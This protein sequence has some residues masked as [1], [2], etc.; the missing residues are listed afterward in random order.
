MSLTLK[1][2]I[3]V[4]GKQELSQLGL[5][6]SYESSDSSSKA[7][8]SSLVHT[9][10]PSS[11]THGLVCPEAAC[12]GVCLGKSSVRERLSSDMIQGF[13]FLPLSFVDTRDKPAPSQP[14]P[15]ALDPTPNHPTPPRL[16]LL[17]PCRISVIWF[18]SLCQCLVLD[19]KQPSDPIKHSS[20]P[21]NLAGPRCRKKSS[22]SRS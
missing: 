18:P 8:K 3:R 21:W 20:C 1:V 6:N 4:N 15:S 10:P 11:L 14:H 16:R 17:Q 13:I 2:P 7:K 5:R 22:G 12:P 19:R 9:A